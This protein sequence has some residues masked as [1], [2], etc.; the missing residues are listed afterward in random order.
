MRSFLSPNQPNATS[1]RVEVAAIRH[2]N[3]ASLDL[4]NHAASTVNRGASGSVWGADG[5]VITEDKFHKI[6]VTGL[7]GI[8]LLDSS[9]VFAVVKLKSVNHGWVF[10]EF[11]NYAYTGKGKSIHLSMQMEA[12]GLNVND[13]HYNFG[14][15]LRIETPDGYKFMLGMED[16][17]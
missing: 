3:V 17:M 11:H 9:T 13:K 5:R 2:Y 15:K 7:G 4:E 10:G 8:K 6:K 12:F 16:G 1:R 14:G